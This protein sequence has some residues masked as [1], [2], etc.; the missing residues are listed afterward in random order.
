MNLQYKK[1][2]I[3]RD[4][5]QSIL[6][7]KYAPGEKLPK[8]EFFSRELGVSRETLRIVLDK[9]EAENLIL[10]L[11]S[12]GTFVR[13]H[14]APK[15]RFLV[16]AILSGGNELPCHA[17]MP[18]IEHMAKAMNIEIETCDYFYFNMQSHEEIAE[19]LKTRNISGII[20]IANNFNGNEKIIKLLEGHNVPVLLSFASRSDYQITGWAT[21]AVAERAAWRDALNHLRKM[22]HRRIVT[23]TLENKPIREYSHSEYK[24]LL[25]EIGADASEDLIVYCPFESKAIRK[26][27]KKVIDRPMQPTAIMCFSDFWAPDVY[28]AVKDAGLRIPEDIAVMGFASGFNCEY[29]HPTLS[30]INEKFAELGGKAVEVLAKADLWFKPDDHPYSAPFIVSEYR[31]EIRESTNMRRFEEQI[32]KHDLSLQNA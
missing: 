18:G 31:L 8:E 20:L 11:K 30:T 7:G 10:R 23:M 15:K 21:L 6:G 17:I 28:H 22:G 27:V 25:K 32:K 3:Y 24:E 29:I 2:I 16:V 5:K 4:L 12:K 13:I 14:E 1:D 9:L 26:A 19:R